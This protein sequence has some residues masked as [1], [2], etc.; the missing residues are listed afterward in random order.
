LPPQQ[1]PGQHDD[2]LWQQLLP[3]QLPGQHF[4]PIV[5]QEL[6]VSARADNENSEAAISAITLAFMENLLSV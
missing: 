4:A 1:S 5:Q 6:P 2:P 3:Q